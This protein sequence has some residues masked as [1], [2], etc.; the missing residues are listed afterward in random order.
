MRV[1]IVMSFNRQLLSLPSPLYRS[2]S[3]NK[4]NTLLI[5]IVAENFIS[6][7]HLN[8]IFTTECRNERD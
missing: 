8:N 1:H 4:K 7:E 2:L 5:A 3:A 6:R